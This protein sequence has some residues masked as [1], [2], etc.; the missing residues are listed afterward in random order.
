MS[1]LRVRPAVPS[2]AETLAAV[3]RE[4]SLAALAHIFPPE[5]YPFPDDSVN[6]R[7]RD[8][9]GGHDHEVFVAERDGD[10][11]GMVAV[12]D[13]DELR[14][15]FVRPSRWGDGTAVALHDQAVRRGAHQLWVLAENWRAR[16]F[17]ERRGWCLDGR[18]QT[19]P[20]PPYPLEVRY[21]LESRSG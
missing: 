3:Q 15:L 11:A 21:G 17:Y 14:G 19:C 16:R 18:E 9:V 13:G 8:A 4:A 5:R 10:V 7:W 20:Y 1:S 6:R 12:R 2:D